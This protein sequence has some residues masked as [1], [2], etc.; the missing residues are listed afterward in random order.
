MFLL[1]TKIILKFVV[2][3]IYVYISTQHKLL[4]GKKYFFFQNTS[5]FEIELKG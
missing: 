1:I 2:N 4:Y 3:K 5:C